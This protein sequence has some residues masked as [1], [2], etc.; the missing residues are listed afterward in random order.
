MANHEDENQ[1]ESVAEMRGVC[2]FE[3]DGTT[4][5][6]KADV[7]AVARSLSEERNASCWQQ[8]VVGQEVELAEQCF[9]IFRFNQH[10]WTTV[11]ARDHSVVDFATGKEAKQLSREI[12]QQKVEQARS[13]ELNEEDARLLSMRLKTRTI[14][15]GV[16]DTACALSYRIYENGELLEKLETDDGYEILEWGQPFMTLAQSKLEKRLR[17][18]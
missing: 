9:F 3:Y 6:V 17:S 13:L 2:T 16:S 14:Y 10:T 5:F 15:Y 11:I 18:G 8:N 1:N 7:E 12:F 4:L